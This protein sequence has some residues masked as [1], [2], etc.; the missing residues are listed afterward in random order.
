MWYHSY[1]YALK[2]ITNW[3]NSYPYGVT[4]APE[5]IKPVGTGFSG[6]VTGSPDYDFPISSFQLSLNKDRIS[7]ISLTIPNGSAHFDAIDT[8]QNGNIIV[9]KF[10]FLNDNTQTD[11]IEFANFPF[12]NFTY[13]SGGRS[14][15]INLRGAE[16]KT[17][18]TAVSLDIG[19]R[20]ISSSKNIDDVWTV[21][22]PADVAIN[23]GDDLTFG[24]TTITLTSVSFRVNRVESVQTVVGS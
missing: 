11:E 17:Y 22:I 24:S 10:V 18:D 12:D 15:S 3:P 23:P 16:T 14:N 5:T 19:E 9:N 2:A 21:I 4:K 7:S 1:P 20:Y 13:D 6:T 8:R